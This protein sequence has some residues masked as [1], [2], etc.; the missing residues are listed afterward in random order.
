MARY[1][2]GGVLKELGDDAGSRTMFELFLTRWG[3]A[4]T[5]RFLSSGGTSHAQ[6]V[7]SLK[8]ACE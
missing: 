4:W 3:D 1:Y 6:S 7:I 2:L 8:P 5:G